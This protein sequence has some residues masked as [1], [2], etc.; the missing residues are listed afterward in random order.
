M[1]NIKPKI[2]IITVVFNGENTIK[3]TINSIVNQS[4]L[5]YEYIIIDGC[6]TD[7]TLNI[8]NEFS[9]KISHIIS[10]PDKGIFDAMNKGLLVA[11][12]EWIIF[13]NSGDLLYEK[14]TLFKVFNS[15]INFSAFDLIYGDVFLYD[16][17]DAYL[18][19]SKTSKI[20]INLN[21]ICHQ[22]VLIRKR[23][24]DFFDLR[25]K[26][27]AD[28][29]IIYK[30]FKSNKVFYTNFIISKIL[31]GGVSSN[32]LKTRNEKFL[33]TWEC[34]N[35]FDKTFAILFYVYGGTKEVV[36][37]ILVK[38][39]PYNFFTFFRNLKNSI[40]SGNV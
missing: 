22:S 35:L 14:D 38:F 18:F 5:N 32:L 36:K 3:D 7:N 9:D 34:G 17:K 27:S 15:N 21:A 33:I 11:K 12:G 30:L 40:E 6:S 20:K 13:I 8:I 24:H 37:N 39:F 16:N 1:I 25:Y 10:E 26:L 19:K 31:I 28:H 29:K 2:S 23:S 4:F